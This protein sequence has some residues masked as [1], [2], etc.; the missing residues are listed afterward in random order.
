MG[1]TSLIAQFERTA[2]TRGARVLYGGGGVDVL[3]NEPGGV[4]FQPFVE[5]LGP[6]VYDAAAELDAAGMR[7]EL[8]EL[9]RLMPAGVAGDGGPVPG[10]RAPAA[11]MAVPR[12]D[13]RARPCRR[14]ARDRADP[15]R[16]TGTGRLHRAAPRAS[17]RRRP[18]PGAADRRRVT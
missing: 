9:G 3:E 18:D 12:G 16:R 17:A 6:H 5:A 8:R 1:K 14:V 10:L 11:G 15:R 13:N 2:V 7:A 4:P